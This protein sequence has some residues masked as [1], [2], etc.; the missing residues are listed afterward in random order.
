MIRR[1]LVVICLLLGTVLT[2]KSQK[3]WIEGVVRLPE[4]STFEGVFK[5]DSHV[6]KEIILLKVDN[7]LIALPPRDV[8]SA[9]GI[10]KEEYKKWVAKKFEA[11]KG[12]LNVSLLMEE[13]HKGTRYTLYRKDLSFIKW[14]PYAD[15][16]CDAMAYDSYKHL[17]NTDALILESADHAK[18][19]VINRPHVWNASKYM[20][21]KNTLASY[22]DVE[23]DKLKN[24]IRRN[25]LNLEKLEDILTLLVLVDE[26]AE[27]QL[28]YSGSNP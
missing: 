16:L 24:L 23:K 11:K 15:I 6:D 17:I 13:V 5:I 18:M 26:P 3:H 12:G 8:R 27:H 1:K 21:N 10:V 25:N 14:S 22:L 9:E 19:L 7:R 4:D 20:I 2:C 28:T